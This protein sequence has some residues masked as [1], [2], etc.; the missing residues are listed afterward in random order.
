MPQGWDQLAAYRIT[1]I[2]RVITDNLAV[3]NDLLFLSSTPVTDA[4]EGDIMGYYEGYD[5]SADVIPDDQAAVVGGAGRI[6]LQSSAVPNLKRGRPISQGMFNTLKRINRGGGVPNDE[7]LVSNYVR[8]ELTSVLKG[9]RILMNRM[10][11]GMQMDAFSYKKGGVT[12]ANV[13]WGMPA[14][15]KFSPTIPWSTTGSATPITD[16]MAW[17]EAAATDTTAVPER[18]D[19]LTLSTKMWRNIRA[20]D[21]FRN[22]AKIYTP[23]ANDAATFANLVRTTAAPVLFEQITGLQIRLHD[24]TYRDEMNDGTTAVKR[25]QPAN[26]GI[27]GVRADDANAD[28]MDF[29]NAVVNETEMPN[30]PGLSVVGGGFPAPAFGPVAYATLA[31]GQLN[32][33]G[34]NLWGVGR[35]FPRKLRKTATA[36]IT[37]WTAGAGDY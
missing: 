16:L 15:R 5:V 33:P 26:I 8:N 2:M 10:L 23:V 13:S 28:A 12:F 1:R 32:P 37:A 21:D 7:G 36:K 25:V 35:G 3:P 29:A 27:L 22:Q 17:L 9:V 14:S 24:A 34:L 11:C 4:D 31:N 18:Y 30:L 19:R 20:T 6:N